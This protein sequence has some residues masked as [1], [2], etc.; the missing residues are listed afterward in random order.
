MDGLDYVLHT[1]VR[2]DWRILVGFT[3]TMLGAGFFTFW[4]GH[5][6]WVAAAGLAG[7]SV[8]LGLLAWATQ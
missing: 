7:M 3:L 8:G 6:A 4:R 5:K 1:P 2:E